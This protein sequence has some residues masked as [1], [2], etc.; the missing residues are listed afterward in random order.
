MDI[1]F[2]VGRMIGGSLA[3]LFPATDSKGN[4]KFK[5]GTNEPLMRVNFGVAIAKGA[6]QHWAHTAWGKEIWAIGAA[7]YP[8]GEFNSPTFAWKV[9]DG[10]SAIPNKKGNRPCDQTGYKGNWVIWFSQSWLPKKV[11]ANGTQELAEPDAIVPGYFVQVLANC[12]D[13]KP[14]ESPGVYLN[15]LAVALSGYGEIIATA[16]DV[17][18]TSVGFGGT[19]LPPGASTTPVGMVT[20]PPAMNVAP[21]GFTGGPPPAMPPGVQPH[22]GFLAGPPVP[23][24]PPPAAP[25]VTMTAKANGVTHEAFVAAGWT[26]EALLREGYMVRV[27][28]QGI[29]L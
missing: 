27:D 24:V 20:P 28:A 29:P 19:A 23:P 18:T 3:K 1:L 6:E 4:P 14:S 15:P 8:N 2:P 25:T 16:S 10:D 12:K 21:V 13:N 26:D 17:D 11:N 9:T 22:P 5:T 7:G